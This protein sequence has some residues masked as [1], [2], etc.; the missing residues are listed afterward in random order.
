MCVADIEPPSAA[1][2]IY[3]KRS[4]RGR[5]Q[6][7][8]GA[9]MHHLCT[10]ANSDRVLMTWLCACADEGISGGAGAAQT[11]STDC[12]CPRRRPQPRRR[13]QAPPRGPAGVIGAL[14][15]CIVW[16][17]N[18]NAPRMHIA[19]RT[20]HITHHTLHIVYITHHTLHITHHIY[21]TSHI[22]HYT[23][24]ISHITY[25][26]LHITYITYITYITRHTSHTLNFIFSH[27]DAD[28]DADAHMLMLIYLSAGA[29]WRCPCWC[30]A[31]TVV[32]WLGK[33][34]VCRLVSC[35]ARALMWWDA[36]I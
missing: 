2:R 31:P 26:T 21:H 30:G 18:G 27:A 32:A 4:Q 23:S 13:L 14:A 28:A 20:S 3:S 8:I 10:R 15:R 19:T 36:H 35:G 24:H 29:A 7:T 25:Y 12:P 11:A 5:V 17:S 1:S 34:G 9:G 16:A 6:G 22:T 33:Q